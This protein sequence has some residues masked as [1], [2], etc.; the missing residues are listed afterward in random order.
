[1]SVSLHEDPGAFGGLESA[2][3]YEEAKFAVLPLPY[4]GTSTWLKGAARG[5]EAIIAA[6]AH[7]EL[8]DIETRSEPWRKGM[9][10]MAPVTPGPTVEITVDRIHD[11]VRRLLLDGKTVIGLG[12]EH[13]VSIGLI[14]AHAERFPGLKVLQLDAHADTRDSYEGT[15]YNHACVMAR[16][17]EVC[18]FVQVGIR[19]M[20]R[21]E[22]D[23]YRP[24]R[25][26]YA[27]EIDR[28]T[29]WI[30]DVVGCLDGP[31]YVTVDLDVLDP[32]EMPSTGTPEPG[33]LRYRQVVQLLDAVSSSHSIV[34]FDVV[35]LLP[36]PANRAPDFLA[37]RLAY[38]IAA[39]LV[40][41]NESE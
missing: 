36:N 30:S 23:L 14:R 2:F 6:S 12:G 39:F 37:A 38:Q 7:M 25:V 10:T 31:V 11:R 19:S 20:D 24:H 3:S 34:G 27:H 4:D 5:P 29:D 15:P 22:L 13:S 8:Y 40:R 41:D 21:S 18:D 32:S 28:S 1:M 16:T 9:I 33:G 26:F 35:E 17:A